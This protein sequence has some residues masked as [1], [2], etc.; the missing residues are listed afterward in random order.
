MTTQGYYRAIFE[1]SHDI[2]LVVGADGRILDINPAGT[3]LYG[4]TL[5]EIRELPPGALFAKTVSPDLPKELM[6]RIAEQ[7]DLIGEVVHR[8]KNGS[9]VYL[10][11]R[12]S[13]IEYERKPA[14]LSILRDLTPRLEAEADT[15]RLA[16]I[17]DSSDDAIFG[18]DLDGTIVSWNEGARRMY[19]YTADEIIGRNTSVLLPPDRSDE[20]VRILGGIVL[21][22]RFDQ[23]ETV[24]VAKGGRLIDVSITISPVKNE[25]GDIVGASSVARDIT[26]RKRAEKELA[27]FWEHIEELI[28]ER[29]AELE[30]SNER[31]TREA[32]ERKKAEMVLRESEE[33]YRAIFENTGTATVIVEDDTTIS[34]ANAES[35]KLYGCSKEELE[36]KISWT[37]YVHPDDLDMVMEYHHL[38]RLDPAAVPNG[39]EYRMI[40]RSGE[41]RHVSVFA[42]LIPGTRRSVVSLVDITERKRAEE[43]IVKINQEL[44]AYD[45]AVSHDLRGPISIIIS[46]SQVLQDMIGDLT[47]ECRAGPV[48]QL[49]GTIQAGAERAISL[50]GDML[51]LAADGQAPRKG[52]L[53]DVLG[54]IKMVLDDFSEKIEQDDI[55]IELDNELGRISADPTHIYQIFSNLIGNSIM[56]NK[57]SGLE[58]RIKYR[59]GDQPGEHQYLLSD[60]GSGIPEEALDR[61]FERLYH[62]EGCGTGMG[63]AIVRQLAGI[64]AGEIKAYNEDGACFELAL[65]DFKN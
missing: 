34:L 46:A 60:N 45:H 47:D 15:R 13:V 27:K 16:A 18:K 56:H 38:R 9:I 1:N 32:S 59:K 6:G 44:E 23:F 40:D 19:G 52:Q 12:S 64:Y 48:Q 22:E 7:G 11:A 30:V 3:E 2:I 35:A 61:I 65:R 33:R 42:E 62:G 54:I 25:A 58:I 57:G 36:G 63:L 37:E 14:I 39:Y 10:E 55:K 29:T 53:V 8:R 20:L 41:I 21:G 17:V 28:R 5:E 31:L 51:T 26:E 24:R 4:Y 49:C 43:A 50:I